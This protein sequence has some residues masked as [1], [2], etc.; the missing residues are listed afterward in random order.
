M[1]MVP[2][3]VTGAGGRPDALTL[4]LVPAFWVGGAGTESDF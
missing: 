2:G 4:E 3:F 1:C